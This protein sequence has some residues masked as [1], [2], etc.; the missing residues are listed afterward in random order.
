MSIFHGK[1][2]S[3]V[4]FVYVALNGQETKAHLFPKDTFEISSKGTPVLT[5]RS[6]GDEWLIE[7]L[8]PAATF[9]REVLAWAQ[10]QPSQIS[11]R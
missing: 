11:S 2:R 9:D 5:I 7:Q 10:Q 8:T 6:R 4:K 3:D 1:P